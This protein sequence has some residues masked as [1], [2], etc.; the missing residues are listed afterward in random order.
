MKIVLLGITG[1]GKSTIAQ[2]ISD[3]FSLQVIEADNE[4]I[5]LN[6]GLWPKDEQIIDKYFEKTS[7]KVLEMDNIV[8]VI[9]WL[10][11]KRVKQFSDKGFKII[12]LHASIEVLLK[13]KIQR[14]N[15]AESEINRFKENFN[16]YYEVVFDEKVKPLITLSLDT[17]TMKPEEVLKEI[18]IALNQN[19]H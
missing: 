1:S 13:R 5:R 6:N 8:Y 11:K 18:T 15:P 10:S 9:S 4:V 17:T 12:E 3:V 2:K 14:D 16:G 7:D 19:G